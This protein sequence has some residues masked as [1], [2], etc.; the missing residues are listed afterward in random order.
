MTGIGNSVRNVFEPQLSAAG[1]SPIDWVNAALYEP[2]ERREWV[3]TWAGD[4]A[5]LH[6]VLVNVV[7][8]PLKVF[9]VANGVLPKASLPDAPF[10]ASDL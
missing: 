8:V 1:T 10:A 9:G 3:L 2:V 4:E 5:V 6:G 7:D